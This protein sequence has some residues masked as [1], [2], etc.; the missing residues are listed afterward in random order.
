[1]DSERLEYFGELMRCVP[2]WLF[3]CDGDMNLLRASCQDMPFDREALPAIKINP[4]AQFPAVFIAESALAWIIAKNNKADE[5]MQ[6]FILGP[7]FFN[8][9]KPLSDVISRPSGDCPSL[10]MEEMQRYAMMLNK[11]VNAETE[12]TGTA[13][14]VNL[15]METADFYAGAG[16]GADA[17]AGMYP[18]KNKNAGEIAAGEAG[19]PAAL[20]TGR[21]LDKVRN[22][23][24]NFQEIAFEAMTDSRYIQSMGAVTMERAKQI[25]FST[26]DMCCKAALESGVKEK[27]ADALRDRHVPIIASSAMAHEIMRQ[28]IL[29]IYHLIRLVRKSKGK[30]NFSEPV[31]DCCIYIQ[32][33]ANEPITIEFLAKQ[34]GYSADH[35][36]KK[37]NQEVGAPLK[38]YIMR[39]KIQYARILLTTTSM[40]IGEIADFFCFSSNSH[41]TKTFQRYVHGTPAEYRK[42]YTHLA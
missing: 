21:L 26:M 27:A 6:Y 28:C 17:D 7:A 32:E 29:F 3:C 18:H 11:T 24:F 20:L 23:D 4:C 40:P 15:E 36:S 8:E 10:T 38:G 22:G 42:K 34:A 13:N 14:T 12:N 30:K 16:A 5:K 35:L 37:F 9:Q 31:H 19:A 33:H 2:L 39:A 25:V 1:M 41:F